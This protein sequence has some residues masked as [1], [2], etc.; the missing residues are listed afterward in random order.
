MLPGL[1]VS[2]GAL[3]VLFYF[4]DLD[5]MGAALRQ[6]NARFILLA[7][8]FTL[9]WLLIRSLAWR[10]L[11][12]ERA[13]FSDVFWTLNEGYL[14]N[15]LLPFRLGEVGRALLLGQKSGLAFWQ[16]LPTILV[17]RIL[18]LSLAVG[19]LLATVP[20]VI[21]AARAR[22]VAAITGGVMLAGLVV[23][24]LV[25]RTPELVMRLY[26]WVDA[27]FGGRLPLLRRLGTR[28][29]PSFLE[30]LAVFK[31]GRRFLLAVG[32]MLLNWILGAAQYVVTMQAFFPGAPLLW[33]A[34]TLGIA[35]MGVAAP[36]S[37][38]SLGV[39][40]G[41]VVFALSLFGQDAS[42]SLALAFTLHLIQIG[43]TGVL[44]AIALARD[45]ES[46]AG[47]YQKLKK[48][49]QLTVDG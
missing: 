19:L 4:A 43:V 20:F 8:V 37:P 17:E 11:L 18:D 44:G 13:R 22:E 2:L 42:T 5:K 33:G 25:G 9:G 12:R 15:N 26:G 40:E 41:S 23:L 16:V 24:D 46:L 30:G 35:A 14:L 3:A 1:L 49:R 10:T 31:D 39:F 32:W 38:G 29:L 45:G 34:F 21:G 36:S 48:G 47:L 6:A 27:R 7:A 28:V